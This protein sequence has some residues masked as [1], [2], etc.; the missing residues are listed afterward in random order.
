[1]VDAQGTVRD[2][3]FLRRSDKDREHH[4]MQRIRKKAR[5]HIRH[6]G[7]LPAGFCSQDHRRLK[8]L[9]DNEAHQISRGLVDLAVKLAC[10]AVVVEQLKGWRPKAGRKRSP[11]K[12]RFHR[13][14]HRMLVNRV[15]SQAKELGLCFLAV[16][17]RGTSSPAFDGSGPVRRES[18]NDSLCTL[19]SGKRYH[20][21]LNAAYNIAARGMVYF[22]GGKR[23][24]SARA[25]QLKSDRTPGIPVT[26]STLWEP[27]R[28]A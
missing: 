14:F 25:D 11:M 13:W 12:A 18:K 22:Q 2:R 23:K 10:Q 15:E 16:Y 27:P 9:A 20:A 3:G 19:S 5:K 6:G 26:L 24:S 17:P 7:R 1:M 4:L 8:Q 21:D 28:V